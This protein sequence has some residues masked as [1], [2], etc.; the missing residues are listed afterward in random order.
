[1]KRS[2]L[3]TTVITL[4][5]I[6]ISISGCYYDKEELLYPGNSVCDTIAVKYSTTVLPIISA[7]CYSCHAGSF[8]SGGIKV[9]TYNDLRALALNGKLYG[10]ISYSAGYQ[11]MPKNLPQLSACKIATIKVWIDAGAPNN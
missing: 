1:M 10:T 8:P 3:V 9:D 4:I 2:N 6:V 5:V 11:P 7:S